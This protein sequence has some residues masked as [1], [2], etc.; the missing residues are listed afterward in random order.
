MSLWAR[1]VLVA[2]LGIAVLGNA[3]CKG[4]ILG[5]QYEYEEDL[6][7]S[8][9]GSATLVV[10]SSLPALVALRGIDL[11]VAPLTR[12]DLNKV[13]A[14]YQSPV[15]RGDARQP[16]MATSRAP[17]RADPNERQRRA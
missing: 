11:D 1:A 10:N 5:K 4:G 2:V 7:L 3:A 8:L 12:L 17:V 13:R 14:V 6:Y 15:D 9:D 16:A